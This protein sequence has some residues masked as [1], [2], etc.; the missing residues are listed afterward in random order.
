MTTWTPN[1]RRLVI[2]GGAG[3]VV[4]AGAVVNTAAVLGDHTIVDSGGMG[5]VAL[6]DVPDGAPVVGVPARGSSAALG[7]P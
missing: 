4:L 1:D 5:A 2:V 7:Q 3:T 6:R